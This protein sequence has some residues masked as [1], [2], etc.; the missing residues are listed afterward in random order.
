MK[1]LV[2]RTRFIDT[3]SLQEITNF[4]GL[5]NRGIVDKIVQQ[6]GIKDIHKRRRKD[7]GYSNFTV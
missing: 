1:L 4:S 6:R 5:I 7:R 2:I 3:A